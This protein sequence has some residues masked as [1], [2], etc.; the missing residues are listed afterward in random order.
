M[1]DYML[2]GGIYSRMSRRAKQTAAGTLAE[3]LHARHPAYRFTR[4]PDVG[5]D[6]PIASP[7]GRQ[8]SFE[9]TGPNDQSA[10]V[11]ARATADSLATGLL[12]WYA[13]APGTDWTVLR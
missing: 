1:W 6:R 8:A 3:V 9:I 11:H 2:S 10:V 7:V 13:V 4:L 12:R 5:P